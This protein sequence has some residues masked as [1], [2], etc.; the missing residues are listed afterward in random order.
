MNA[1]RALI[2]SSAFILTL[3]AI[4]SAGYHQ[5]TGNVTSIDSETNTIT[6]QGRK[7]PVR[8]ITDG[9]T[10][11]TEEVFKTLLDVQIGDKVTVKYKTDGKRRNARQIQIRAVTQKNI[12]AI[13]M[14]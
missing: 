7:G 4:S 9:G 3:A 2:L 12:N 11:V 14:Q 1:L 6:V 10:R 5:V 8:V 13:E